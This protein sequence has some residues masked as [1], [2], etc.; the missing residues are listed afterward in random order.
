MRYG[1]SISQRD[2]QETLSFLTEGLADRHPPVWIVW[3]V[4]D[5]DVADTRNDDDDQEE[6]NSC[7][8]KKKMREKCHP[9]NEKEGKKNNQTK[10]FLT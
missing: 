7:L 9:H 6:G 1:I 4:D 2:K 8:K 3:T 10:I 5:D